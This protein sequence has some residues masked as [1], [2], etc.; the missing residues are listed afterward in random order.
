VQRLTYDEAVDGGPAWS[1][2]GGQIA[3]Y[4]AR[5]GYTEIYV[6][7]ADG[8]NVRRLTDNS[9]ADFSPIWSPDG[10]QI[11]FQSER[12]GNFEIY[13]MDADGGNVRRLT[14]D[15]AADGAPAWSPDG[16]QITFYSAR[17]GD[18]EIYVMDADGGNVRRLTDSAGDDYSPAWRPAG[19]T[20]TPLLQSGEGEE[21][22]TVASATAVQ[23]NGVI[24]GTVQV[25]LRQGPGT[26][27]NGGSGVRAERGRDVA[28]TERRGMGDSGCGERERGCDESAGD[29][30]RGRHPHPLTPTPQA[31]RGKTPPP[32]PMSIQ[33]N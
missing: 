25:N 1:P 12:D 26:A 11:V 14:D 23:L 31:E 6:M 9:A 32:A 18:F 22:G 19:E 10:R 5:D 24:T 16:R 8:G 33:A 15:P 20:L 28:E 29:G 2:D 27:R 13:V 21:G 3:F 4:S 7:D 17:D 30:M